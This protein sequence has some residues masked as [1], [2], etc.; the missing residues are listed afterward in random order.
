M[1]F[2]K[3]GS[4][5]EALFIQFYSQVENSWEALISLVH[6]ANPNHSVTQSAGLN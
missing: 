1:G 5:G 2:N 3:P 6:A 4:Q